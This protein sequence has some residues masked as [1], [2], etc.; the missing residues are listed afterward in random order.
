MIIIVCVVAIPII[1]TTQSLT[2]PAQIN[3]ESQYITKGSITTTN[4][5][6]SD[7]PENYTS[8]QLLSYCTSNENQIYNDVCIRG[9]WDISDQC[10]NEN[11]SDTNSICNDSKFTEFENRVDKE[12]QDLDK[13]LTQFVDSCNKVALDNDTASCSLNIERIQSD[14][15]DS[16]FYEMMSICKN[17]SLNLL[18]M[19][20]NNKM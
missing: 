9:L 10:K 6:S 13:S 14:C 12:M 15:S 19:K 8:I 2:K 16:R 5:N 11:F 7:L 18:L 17:P 1:I 3:N 4:T 20:Y